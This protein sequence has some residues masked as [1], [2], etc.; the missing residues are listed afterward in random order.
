LHPVADPRND[1]GTKWRLAVQGRANR[2]R[3]AGTQVH[4]GADHRGRAEIEGNA[5]A[6][7]ARISRLERDQVVTAEHGRHLELGL[8][9]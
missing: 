2:L 4:Q 3:H 8:A 1:V 6:L 9:K 7:L 5:V